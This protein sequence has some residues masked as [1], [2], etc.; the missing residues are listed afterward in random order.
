MLRKQRNT[1]RFSAIRLNWES[2]LTSYGVNSHATN[3]QY[4]DYGNDGTSTQPMVPL[5]AVTSYPSNTAGNPIYCESIRGGHLEGG[6]G[7]MSG[8]IMILYE[9]MIDYYL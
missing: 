1:L 2:C 8:G 6:G 3:N 7:V 5:P 4:K 9:R